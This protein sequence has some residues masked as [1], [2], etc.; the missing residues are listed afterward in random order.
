MSQYIN[1]AVEDTLPLSGVQLVDEF[2]CEVFVALLIP[3]QKTTTKI[4]S[5]L[6]TLSIYHDAIKLQYV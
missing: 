6:S 4:N 5:S 3:T 1:P 2:C